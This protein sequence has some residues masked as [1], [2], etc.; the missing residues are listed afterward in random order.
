MVDQNNRLYLLD[1]AG[2]FN[3]LKSCNKYHII[4]NAYFENEIQQLRQ[5]KKD[6]LSNQSPIQVSKRVTSLS[7]QYPGTP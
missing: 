2:S 1:N 3:Q 5:C 6:T 4:R 7:E